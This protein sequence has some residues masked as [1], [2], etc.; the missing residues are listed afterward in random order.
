M[1]H[2]ENTELQIRLQEL[3]ADI[4]INLTVCFGLIAL[5]FTLLIGFEQIFM[6]LPAEMVAVKLVILFANLILILVFYPVIQ[7]HAQKVKNA[8]N[9]LSKLRNEY[10]W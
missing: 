3:Q 7:L 8:R 6:V 10:H 4:Q 2:N 1:L 5:L 9:Q